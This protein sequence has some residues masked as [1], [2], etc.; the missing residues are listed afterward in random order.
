MIIFQKSDHPNL[1]ILIGPKG[2]SNILVAK[3]NIITASIT[4][5]QL[6]KITVKNWEK[7]HSLFSIDFF[8]DKWFENVVTYYMLNNPTS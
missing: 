4:D 1:R 7:V 8:F 5:V 2:L 3:Y 6:T